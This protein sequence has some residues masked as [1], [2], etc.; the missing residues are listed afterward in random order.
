SFLHRSSD[1]IRI[2]IRRI[3]MAKN[4]DCLV[5][6]EMIDIHTT[7]QRAGMHP[8]PARMKDTTSHDQNK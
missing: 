2:G 3:S 5:A 1:L 4:T 7:Y 8:C 6:R